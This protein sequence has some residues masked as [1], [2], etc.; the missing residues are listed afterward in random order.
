MWG[1]SNKASTLLSTITLGVTFTAFAPAQSTAMSH[2]MMLEVTTGEVI[3]GIASFYDD[4]GE[5]ASGEMYD[6]DAFT[7]AALIEIRGKFGGIRFGRLYQPSYA[8]AEY[9]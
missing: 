8:I 2:S 4:P 6:P 7:A 5:T 9:G 3:T 1:Q